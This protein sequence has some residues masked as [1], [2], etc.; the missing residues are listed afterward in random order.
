MGSREPLVGNG[1]DDISDAL[2]RRVEI[3]VVGC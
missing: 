1:R 3:R 2:D